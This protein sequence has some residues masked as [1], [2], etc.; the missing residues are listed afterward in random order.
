MEWVVKSE[1]FFRRFIGMAIHS[2]REIE[3]IVR[4]VSVIHRGI[5]S[6]V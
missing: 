6:G 4:E 3:M 5:S 1:N 2:W